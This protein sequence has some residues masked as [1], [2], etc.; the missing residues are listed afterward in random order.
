[1]TRPEEVI[2]KTCEFFEGDSEAINHRTDSVASEQ[3]ADS[4]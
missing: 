4:E 3:R 1:M 2:T